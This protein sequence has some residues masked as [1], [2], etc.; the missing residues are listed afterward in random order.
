MGILFIYY[1]LATYEGYDGYVPGLRFVVIGSICLFG[2]SIGPINKY[3]R[4]YKIA[5][6][7]RQRLDELL[8]IYKLDYEVSIN[9]INEAH[10]GYDVEKQ[11]K[12]F[13]VG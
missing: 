11:V 9:I 1:L 3:I 7:N 13:R 10:G 12:I 8:K 5:K 4:D 6:N 2:V